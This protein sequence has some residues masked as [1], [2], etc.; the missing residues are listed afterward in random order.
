MVPWFTFGMARVRMEQAVIGRGQLSD[1]GG[2][3]FAPILNLR[4][5]VESVGE[6]D[7]TCP[8]CD[9]ILLRRVSPQVVHDLTFRCPACGTYCRVP[10][11]S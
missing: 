9:A 8:G 2:R 10:E 4:A 5:G 11:R 7:F 6:H 1:P 3:H